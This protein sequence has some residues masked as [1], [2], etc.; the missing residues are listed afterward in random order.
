MER[1]LPFTPEH[2]MLR[3]AFSDFL[4]NEVVPYYNEWEEK[5]IVPREVY[6]KMGDYGFLC[7]WVDEKYGGRG[8]TFWLRW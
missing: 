6:K 2:E 4:D 5:G 3:R 1:I 8:P 7:P